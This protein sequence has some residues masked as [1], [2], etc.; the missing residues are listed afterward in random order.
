VAESLESLNP[1]F[2]YSSYDEAKVE[3]KRQ[4]CKAYRFEWDG[5]DANTVSNI[6]EI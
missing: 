1:D 2:L 5:I 6:S 3:A 4:N